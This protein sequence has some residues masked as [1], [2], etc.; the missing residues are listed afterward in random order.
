MSITFQYSARDT[1]GNV[2]SS[3]VEAVSVEEATQQLRGDGLHV[4]EIEEADDDL[5]SLTARRITKND[6]IY[7]TSQLAIMVETGTTIAHALSTIAEQETS[8]RLRAVLQDLKNSVEAGEDLSVALARHPKQFDETYVSL[9]RASESTGTMGEML[10]RI[11]GYMSKEKETLGKVRSALAYPGCMMVMSIGVTIFLLVYILP[12][13][14]PMFK[15]PGFQLP[16][17]TAFLMKASETLIHHWYFWIA[18]V[19]AMVVGFIFGRRTEKGRRALD[20]TKIHAPIIGGLFRK[21]A[22]TRSIRTLGTMVASG[23]SVLES[24]QLSA[25]V[26]GNIYYRELWLHALNQVTSGKQICEALA[27][28]KLIPPM[29]I[30]MISSGEETGHLDTVLQ[31]VSTFYDNEVDDAIKTTTSMIEPIMITGMG[32]VVGGIAMSLLLPIFSLSKP[33]G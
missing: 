4:T 28:S 16:A 12:K 26:S 6:I 3:S 22:I 9:I 2:H 7:T 25:E 15:R 18:G 10:D 13:F 11:A 20:Y 33:G 17:S 27:G 1:L 32:I 30:R 19:V 31:R 5:S 29:L 23:V 14:E 8:P 21:I 24:L